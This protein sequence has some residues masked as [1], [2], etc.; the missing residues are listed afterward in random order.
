[1]TNPYDMILREFRD[2][3]TADFD[4]YPPFFISSI[5]CHYFNLIN[6]QQHLYQRNGQTENTRLHIIMVAPQGQ[7]KSFWLKQFLQ[8]ERSIVHGTAIQT[9]FELRMTEPGYMGTRTFGKDRGQIIE[10]E[11]LCVEQDKSIVG[12]EEFSDLMKAIDKQDYNVGL[13]NELLTT[14]DSGEGIKRMAAGVIRFHTDLTM[15]AGTQP[16]RFNLVSGLGRRFLFIFNIP[17]EQSIADLR[18]R[19]RAGI[20]VRTDPERLQNIKDVLNH[21][22]DEITMARSVRFESSFYD[23]LNTFELFAHDEILFEKLALGYTLMKA[24]TCEPDI[25]ID[26][27]SK[28]RKMMK[29]EYTW[30]RQIVRGTEDSMVWHYIKSAAPLSYER[31]IDVLLG[32][33]MELKDAE[34][35]IRTLAKKKLIENNGARIYLKD[36]N[37]IIDPADL[38][39]EQFQ[40]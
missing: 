15:W 37:K 6:Q 22:F 19:R 26:M 30:R 4:K 11:G 38:E 5:G 17:T 36:Q 9:D 16:G 29:Q 35:S 21:R 33:G 34:K 32:F 7:S 14:L 31:C 28:L 27:D 24:E 1:M 23:Y 39:Q 3:N 2:R 18:E 13:D 8:G 10:T 25:V 12:I 40:E 20:D